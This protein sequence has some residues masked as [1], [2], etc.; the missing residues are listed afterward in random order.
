MQFFMQKL[1]EQNKSNEKSSTDQLDGS[2]QANKISAQK[3]SDPVFTTFPFWRTA[4][5]AD[6]KTT[7]CQP[8]CIK[9][10]G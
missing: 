8:V 6:N 3:E 1:N 9:P 10:M 5:L 2:D 4:C 7:I